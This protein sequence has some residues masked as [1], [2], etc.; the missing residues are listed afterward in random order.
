MECV[1]PVQYV[2]T[3]M[4]IMITYTDEIQARYP[5]VKSAIIKAHNADHFESLGN[6]AQALECYETAVEQLIPL[7]EG[8][9]IYTDSTCC[10][11]GRYMYY[12]CVCVHV[13]VCAC[14]CACSLNSVQKTS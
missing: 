9:C 14:V 3:C 1:R 13:C 5:G 11:Q 12:V 6:Y 10:C 7:I 4:A 8:T 2:C